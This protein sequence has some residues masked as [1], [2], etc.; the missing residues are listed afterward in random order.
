MKNKISLSSSN[1]YDWNPLIEPFLNHETVSPHW[2]HNSWNRSTKFGAVLTPATTRRAITF[3]PCTVGEIREYRCV[4]F[5]KSF[6]LMLLIRR[7]DLRFAVNQWFSSRLWWTPSFSKFLFVSHHMSQPNPSLSPLSLPHPS[8]SLLL[9]LPPARG[10]TA[11]P[12][13]LPSPSP[14]PAE[15]PLPSSCHGV[16]ER[17]WREV[18]DGNFSK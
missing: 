17:R 5:V 3:N 7:S 10:S 1:I 8:L 18:E 15:P 12:M 16:W 11:A 2:I 4:H 9:A 6:V 13:S 14:W